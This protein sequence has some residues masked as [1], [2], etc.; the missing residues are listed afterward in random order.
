MIHSII[1]FIIGINNFSAVAGNDKVEGII[2]DKNTNA[3]VSGAHVFWECAPMRGVISNEDGVFSILAS[4]DCA[5]LIVTHIGYEPAKCE[6]VNDSNLSIGL[7]E[8]AY[9]LSEITVKSITGL[10]I[11]ENVISQLP[12]NHPARSVFYDFYYREVYFTKDSIIHFVEEHVGSIEHKKGSHLVS[13]PNKVN[14]AKSRIGYFTTQGKKKAKDLRFISL[15]QTLWDNPVFD[16]YDHLNIRKHKQF[17]F[18]YKGTANIYGHDC[19]IVTFSTSKPCTYQSGQLYIDIETSAVV[20]EE[21]VA[22]SG[23]ERRNIAF[24][25]SGN[26]W[27]LSSVEEYK[28]RLSG[29]SHRITLYNMTGDK[30]ANID[31][32]VMGTLLPKFV[33]KYTSSYIESYWD[34]Y[35]TVPLPKWIINRIDKS[36]EV[37]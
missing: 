31:Y 7:I 6:V 11:I 35:N 14:V 2:F 1:V 15:S 37:L 32:I 16:R 18:N 4:E 23:S 34:D 24:V 17:T 9:Q 36:P 19:Y 5:T 3:P 13:F 26:E 30:N 21:L 12:L 20:R 27:Y 22:R 33:T 8:N 10:E 28:Y 29:P 25:K